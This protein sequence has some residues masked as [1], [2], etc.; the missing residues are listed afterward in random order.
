MQVNLAMRLLMSWH[1]RS[2]NFG[3]NSQKAPPGPRAPGPRYWAMSVLANTHNVQLRSSYV[4]DPAI[5]IAAI[6]L[7]EG[8]LRASRQYLCTLFRQKPRKCDGQ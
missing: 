4:Q 7:F 6:K 8:Q 2:R 5:A 3:R 1:V